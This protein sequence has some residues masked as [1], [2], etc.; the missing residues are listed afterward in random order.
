MIA[1]VHY[2]YRNGE[3]YP[4]DHNPQ[5]LDKCAREAFGGDVL[6]MIRCYCDT[7]GEHVAKVKPTFVGHFDLPAKFSTMP[8]TDDRYRTV[9]AD[10]LREIIKI[11]PY[12]GLNTGAMSRGW[13]KI[14]YPADFLLEV[15][16]DHGGRI[17]LGSDAH[18]KDHLTFGF[19][20]S[21]MLLKRKDIHSI[22]VFN[23]TA[24]EAQTI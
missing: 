5:L 17:V 11:C 15:V 19:D 20:E 4:L 12:I 10:A 24:F 18:N 1:S 21:V 2:L 7:L 13:R 3:Y 8:E 14:P 22:W 16:R 6:D 9:M 23:G